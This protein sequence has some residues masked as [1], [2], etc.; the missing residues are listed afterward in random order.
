MS[1]PETGSARPT[2][3]NRRQGAASYGGRSSGGFFGTEAVRESYP[4]TFVLGKVP[5]S[6]SQRSKE[7]ATQTDSSPTT[8]T[9]W[10]ILRTQAP[11]SAD[12]TSRVS[13]ASDYVVME[14]RAL[15]YHSSVQTQDAHLFRYS[16]EQVLEMV[17]AWQMITLFIPA[18]WYLLLYVADQV[19]SVVVAANLCLAGEQWWCG[20]TVTFLVLP[21]LFINA[22]AYEQ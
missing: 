12:D 22:Y 7:V 8:V 18:S 11:D 21:S 2:G 10:K 9:S 1:D 13:A 16:E 15:G 14:T 17:I 4:V 19:S 3:V 5:S 6:N 20:L